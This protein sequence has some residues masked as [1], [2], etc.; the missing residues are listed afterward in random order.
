MKFSS[1]GMHSIVIEE[2]YMD[3]SFFFVGPLPGRILPG[4]TQTIKTK[5]IN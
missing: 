3:P 4:C 5:M 1:N 2:F